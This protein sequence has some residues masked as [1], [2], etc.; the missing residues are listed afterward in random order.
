MQRPNCGCP[1]T[2]SNEHHQ[3]GVFSTNHWL[4]L[5]LNIIYIVEHTLNRKS[6][7]SKHRIRL[8]PA[9]CLA[10]ASNAC[11]QTLA[12]PSMP[13]RKCFT[14]RRAQSATGLL[15][16][17][18]CRMPPTNW[19]GCC[20]GLSCRASRGLAGTCTA[21]NSGHQKDTGLPHTTKIGGHCW[22][23]KR[24]RQQPCTEKTATS[25]Y[26]SETEAQRRWSPWMRQRPQRPQ[27]L[28]R[29]LGL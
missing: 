18:L 14:S 22:F 25:S 5:L 28:R 6:H 27:L 1:A 24:V 19:C 11:A 26:N 21:A 2:H 12:C 17:S 29:G 16:R 7:E 10:N 4:S 9:P 15:A 13:L 23:V 3:G 8:K 20:V